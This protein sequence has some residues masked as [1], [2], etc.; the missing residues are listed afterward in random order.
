MFAFRAFGALRDQPLWL[1]ATI[2]TIT[3]CNAVTLVLLG[4]VFLLAAID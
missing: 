3:I 4:V 2:G 1:R